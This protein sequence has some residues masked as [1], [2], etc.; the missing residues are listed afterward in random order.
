[1]KSMIWYT[2]LF[3]LDQERS[4]KFAIYK[5]DF[6][7]RGRY[8]KGTTLMF[9]E[10]NN[11]KV[12]KI[13]FFSQFRKRPMSKIKLKFWRKICIIFS[14]FKFIEWTFSLWISRITGAKKIKNFA[15]AYKLKFWRNPLLIIDETYRLLCLGATDE[16]LLKFWPF[17][18]CKFVKWINSGKATNR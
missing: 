15:F 9:K 11:N 13:E 18:E 1:M 17:Y 8:K 7:Y 12:E 3:Y 14:N 2:K 6:T 16:K 4:Q 5:D 10:R